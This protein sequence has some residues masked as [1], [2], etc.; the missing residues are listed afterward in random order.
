[1]ELLR[2]ILLHGWKLRLDVRG[3]T[4]S[5]RCPGRGREIVLPDTMIMNH[6]FSTN[7]Y[8][9]AG[10]ARSKPQPGTSQ[11]EFMQQDI[12][13]LMMITEA[14]WMLLQRAH[15]YTDTDLKNL[16]NEIDLRD[17]VLDGRV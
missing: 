9:T 4:P 7:A 6:V 10:D 16:I 14:M 5:K 17:G 11:I 3:E 8:G 12:E 13:R 1:M 15:G 2:R